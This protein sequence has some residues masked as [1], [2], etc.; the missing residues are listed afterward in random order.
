MNVPQVTFDH[1]V[2]GGSA[3]PEP[4][5]RA[6]VELHRYIQKYCRLLVKSLQREI[7]PV[8]SGHFSQS[9]KTGWL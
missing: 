9:K 4:R 1:A 8:K 3:S 5:R 6:S 7:I 2:L